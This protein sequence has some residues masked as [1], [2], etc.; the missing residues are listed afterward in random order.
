[1]DT[2]AILITLGRPEDS[3]IVSSISSVGGV[4]DFPGGLGDSVITSLIFLIIV[5]PPTIVSWGHGAFTHEVRRD[6]S[7]CFVYTLPQV[8]VYINF[9]SFPTLIKVKYG[10]LHSSQSLFILYPAGSNA[11]LSINV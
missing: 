4:G 9:S 3:S 11:E 5:P 2:S 10:I 1:M 6:S 7:G 8:Q